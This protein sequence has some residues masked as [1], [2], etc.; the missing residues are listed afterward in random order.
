MSHFEFSVMASLYS[1]PGRRLQLKE[2]AVLAN[3]S[4]SRLS[5]VVSRLEKRGWVRRQSANRGRATFAQLT[6]DGYRRLAEVGPIHVREVRRLVFDVLAPGDVEALE[7]VTG[8]L[9][10]GLF[11]ALGLESV[12]RRTPGGRPESA[13]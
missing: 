4:L 13:R 11:A 6:D 1:Q 12:V 7:H 10:A 8:R 5:H 2:L 9:N 3:G